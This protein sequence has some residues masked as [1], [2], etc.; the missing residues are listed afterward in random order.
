MDATISQSRTMSTFVKEFVKQHAPDQ[1]VPRTII[2][3]SYDND[4]AH[5]AGDINMASM[6]TVPTIQIQIEDFGGSF[7]MPHSGHSRP[8]ADYFNSNLMVLNFVVADLTS[9][10]ADVL[11]YDERKDADAPC[12]LRFTYHSNKFKIMLE[13][14]QATPKILVVILDNYVEQNKSQ[15]VMQFFAL[16]SITFYTK[17]VLIYL[18]R[19]HSHNTANRIVAWCRNAMKGK[20]FYTPMAI[21]EAITQVKG[22]NAKFIDHHDSQRPCYVGWD[23]LLKKHFNQLPT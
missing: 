16:L 2:P 13:R 14:K 12:N 19:G 4:R 18:I 6:T 10:S 20:N 3:N 9:D 8:S 7:A 15:L 11:F 23:R 1:P 5:D 17:V 21:V 22:V